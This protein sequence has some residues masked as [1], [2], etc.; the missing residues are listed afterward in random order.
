MRGNGE[1]LPSLFYTPWEYKNPNTGEVIEYPPLVLD[2]DEQGKHIKN[3]IPILRGITASNSSNNT[4]YTYLKTCFE[5]G[6]LKLLQASSEV[7]ERY[8]NGNI[9]KEEYQCFIQTDM[10]ISELSNIK[11]DRTDKGNIVYERI[12]KRQKRDRATSLA[13]GLSIVLEKE[14]ENIANL[15]QDTYDENSNY[16]LW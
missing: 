11:Q 1:P 9:S 3:A 12:I 14:E 2:N 4:M 6:T 8:K 13:Y 5:N 10:L 16:V 15:S 7:D